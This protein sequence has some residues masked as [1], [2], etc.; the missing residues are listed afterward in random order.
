MNDLRAPGEATSLDATATAVTGERGTS[1]V[2][3]SVAPPN[4][5][6]PL[7]V[8]EVQ[9]VVRE[10]D[11]LAT[12]VGTQDVWVEELLRYATARRAA[13]AED[14]VPTGRRDTPSV[15]VADRSS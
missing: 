12:R 2:E 9:A 3:A 1:S 14:E 4:V 15:P 11:R 10:G 5:A 13:S 6:E 7:R 8:G